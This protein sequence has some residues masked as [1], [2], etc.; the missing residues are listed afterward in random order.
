MCRLARET[1]TIGYQPSCFDGKKCQ[2]IV[3][4]GVFPVVVV[5]RQ[6]PQVR[7]TPKDGE[8]RQ[9]GRRRRRHDGG[10]YDCRRG[11]RCR[12]SG[13]GH[14]GGFLVWCFYS[15]V[16]L[17]AYPNVSCYR[18]LFAVSHSKMGAVTSIMLHTCCLHTCCRT[19]LPPLHCRVAIE[20]TC[21]H[22]I[23]IYKER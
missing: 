15:F 4:L 3:L 16:L 6:T 13:S 21:V 8:S 22:Y 1:G 11:G 2:R 17:V 12:V 5:G 18:V 14:L 9:V 19:H 20:D 7:A 10:G 23:Q